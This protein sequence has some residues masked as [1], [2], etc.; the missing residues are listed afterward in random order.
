[1][2][3]FKLNSFEIYTL[4]MDLPCIDQ[5]KDRFTVFWKAQLHCQLSVPDYL[6]RLASQLYRHFEGFSV[7]K[8]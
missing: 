1:M 3:N 2:V 5:E 8:R 6:E 7:G 4:T